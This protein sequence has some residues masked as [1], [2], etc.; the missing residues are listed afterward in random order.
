[1]GGRCND[2]LKKLTHLVA[3][4]ETAIYASSG[5]RSRAR[6][7]TTAAPSAATSSKSTIASWA[8][9][10]AA[11]DR[12]HILNLANLATNSKPTVEFR[13][14]AGTLNF[15]KIVGH[16]S[17]CIALVEQVAKDRSHRQLGNR[18]AKLPRSPPT[19]RSAGKSPSPASSINWVG[20]K[21]APNS[22]LAIF[23]AMPPR[24]CPPSNRFKST[25]MSLARKYDKGQED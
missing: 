5:T 6:V 15:S 1:M 12:Y 8:A 20:S 2:Q 18:S 13:A 9:N 14:F 11:S 16:I 10:Y 23:S 17:T 24:A 21:A 19:P 7:E 25:L 22:S 3:N 4:F